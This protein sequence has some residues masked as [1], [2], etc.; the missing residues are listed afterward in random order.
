MAFSLPRTGRG[1]VAYLFSF[2]A[3]SF[4]KFYDVALVS[5]IQ[6]GESAVITHTSRPWNRP[7]LPGTPSRSSQT[8]SRGCR[9]ACAAI[10]PTPMVHVRRRHLPLCGPRS[11]PHCVHSPLSASVSPF[12]PCKYVHQHQLFWIPYICTKNT[13]HCDPQMP[14]FDVTVPWG[15]GV[16]QLPVFPT[17][18]GVCEF[19]PCFWS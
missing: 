12:L 8:G 10:H 6:Q 17:V 14:R 18:P 16:Q 7:S 1:V 9:A 3:F 2:Q 4:F 15:S 19:W 13:S 5:A 11:L